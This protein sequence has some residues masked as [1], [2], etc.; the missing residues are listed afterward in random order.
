MGDDL[1]PEVNGSPRPS[2]MRITPALD[3]EPGRVE[4]ELDRFFKRDDALSI[5]LL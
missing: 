4:S 2:G 1:L 3:V 5:L